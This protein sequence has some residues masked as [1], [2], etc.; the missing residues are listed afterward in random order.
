VCSSDRL[1]IF[2]AV[3]SSVVAHELLQMLNGLHPNIK[4][5]IEEEENCSLP[6]LDIR[7]TREVNCLTT[8]VYRKSTHSGVFTHYTSFVPFYLKS[9]LIR[10]LL[11]RAYEIC[12][13]YELL[14]REFERLRVM[15]LN[16]GYTRDYLYSVIDKFMSRKYTEYRPPLGPKPKDI[17]LRLPYLR[18]VTS[19]LEGSITSC[20]GQMK[21]GSLRVKV[22]YNYFRLSHKLK[23]K[24]RSLTVSNAIYHL[25][26]NACQASYTGETKRNIADRMNEHANPSSDSEVSRHCVENPGHGFN[27]DNPEILAFEQYT[28]K[29]RIKE[30]LFI[31]ERGSILNKQE[32]SYKLFLFDVPNCYKEQ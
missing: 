31:Q 32:K 16:N 22:F 3:E 24:D 20:L 27:F 10:T 9:Q 26:C 28:M 14:H 21:C 23:F 29:R 1:N 15:L 12:S 30:A 13:S 11:H 19:K 25:Q 7:M 2:A 4:F 18:D 8:S 17:Y 6:F 5:T